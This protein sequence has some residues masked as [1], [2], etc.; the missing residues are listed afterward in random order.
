MRRYAFLSLLLLSVAIAQPARGDNDDQ[1]VRTFTKTFPGAGIS[2]LVLD[3]PIG[4][5]EITAADGADLQ[6]EIR[7]VCD[8]DHLRS[9]T[10]RA[11]K[12]TLSAGRSG[13]RVDVRVGKG[14][15]GGNHS[16]HIKAFV[17]APRQLA[18][19]ADLGIG[20]LHIDGFAGDVTADLGVGEVHVSA[21]EAA[22]RSV[23]IE[24]GVGEGH[25]TA[26]GRH[27]SSEGLFTRDIDWSAGTGRARIA[28][29][30]GVG[31][32]HVRLDGGVRT[33]AKR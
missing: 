11:K 9:C 18:V 32:A 27:F 15:G 31:E 28:V 6:V 25:L 13:D 26:A 1:T 3:V 12:L 17:T 2:T 33:A 24:T 5:V 30:C 23:S 20:E 16:L 8:R 10:E 4:A 22:V 19:K 29:D 7:V 21:P 14:A